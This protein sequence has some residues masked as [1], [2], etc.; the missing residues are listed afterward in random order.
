[1]TEE[2]SQLSKEQKALAQSFYLAF[3]TEQGKEVYKHFEQ[4]YHDQLSFD[5]E[6]A[7][8]TDYNEGSRAV[9]LQIKSMV[10]LGKSLM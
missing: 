10:N 8:N 1:M 6:S 5:P 9:F 4:E 3:T 2:A 7:R